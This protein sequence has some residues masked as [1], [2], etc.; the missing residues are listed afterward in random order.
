[1]FAFPMVGKDFEYF[2]QNEAIVS[3]WVNLCTRSNR[4]VHRFA[5]RFGKTKQHLHLGSIEARGFTVWC[6]AARQ[7]F[8]RGF[9]RA[10]T[11]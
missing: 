3:P 7:I 8:Q 2:L 9:A 10:R 11:F 4:L 6:A 1:M 5:A